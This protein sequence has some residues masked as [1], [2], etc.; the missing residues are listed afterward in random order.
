MQEDSPALTGDLRGSLCSAQ[1]PEPPSLSCKHGQGG[2]STSSA[3]PAQGTSLSLGEHAPAKGAEGR[4]LAVPLLSL[5]KG[6]AEPWVGFPCSWGSQQRGKW[7]KENT[8]K[9]ASEGKQTLSPQP[10]APWLGTGS[11]LHKNCLLQSSSSVFKPRS[12]TS[13]K[14]LQLRRNMGRAASLCGTR[15][16]QLLFLC[17]RTSHY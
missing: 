6:T 13:D 2:L 5:P 14:T 12:Y 10:S 7:W 1:N 4:D 3:R 11:A 8:P 15:Q 16:T 17:H 9:L